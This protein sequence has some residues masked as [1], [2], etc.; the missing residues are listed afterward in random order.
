[1]K[2]IIIYLLCFITTIYVLNSTPTTHVWAP[3][4][5]VQPYKVFHITADYYVPI[6]K[7]NNGSFSAPVIN[8]GLTVGVLPFEKF[9]AEVGFDHIAG[10][11]SSDEYPFYFNFKFGIPEDGFGKLFPQLAIG[12]YSIGTKP[13]LTDYN[14]S[15]AKVAKTISPLGKIS[16]G[17]Y[18]GNEKLLLDENG[19][20]DNKG[21]LFAVER[22][23]TEITDKL[24]VCFEYQSGK[25][26]YG[27]TN[28]GFSYKFSNNT[29]MLFGLNFYNNSMIQP[30]YTVQ[31]DID[32]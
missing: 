8:S 3:S 11:G 5:D 14:I 27:T 21:I 30:T 22:T 2:R 15:Y 20:V 4:C 25:N 28:F 26:S 24:W 13:D 18:V 17:V 31:T 6:S 16:L 7:N 12:M 9:Q 29:S 23:I 1:M 19:N 32:F 10:Y